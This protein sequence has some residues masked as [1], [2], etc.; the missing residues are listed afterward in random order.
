MP[1]LAYRLPT[2]STKRLELLKQTK[3]NIRKVA[4]LWNKDTTSA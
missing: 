1:A 2:L 4:M 3:P